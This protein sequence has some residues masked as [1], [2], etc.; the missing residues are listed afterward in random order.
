MIANLADRFIGTMILQKLVVDPQGLL[1]F[2][3]FL[4]ALALPE[5]RTQPRSLAAVIDMDLFKRGGRLSERF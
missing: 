5:E 1:R 3:L 2:S 4:E